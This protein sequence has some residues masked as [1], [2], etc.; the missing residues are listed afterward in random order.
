MTTYCTAAVT[1]ITAKVAAQC[2]EQTQPNRNM[3]K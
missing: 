1:K 3:D 2:H